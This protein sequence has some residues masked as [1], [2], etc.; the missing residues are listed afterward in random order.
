MII[1]DIHTALLPL[2]S[3]TPKGQVF[4]ITD[5]EVCA[6]CIQKSCHPSMVFMREFPTLILPSGEEHKSL[7]SIQKIWDFLLVHQATRQALII[8]LGGG[9]VTDMGG[10]AAATYM[11][12]VRFVNIPTTLLAM[13]DA[14]TGGKTGCNFNGIKN[15]I[16]TF[17]LPVSTLVFPPFL[18]SL[19]AQQWLSGYAEMLKHGLIADPKHWTDLLAWD[20]HTHDISALTP[21]IADSIAIKKHIVEAD[22]KEAGIRRAL[23]F[24]HTIGHAIEAT[25]IHQGLHPY[26]GYC[27]L[28]G[29]V[30]AL[31]LSVVHTACPRHLLTTLTQLMVE[32]YGKPQCNCH[33]QEQLIEWMLHD[34]KN[35]ASNNDQPHIN[36]TLLRDIG[37][38]LINQQLP[39]AAVNEALEYL[40]SI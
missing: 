36:F 18:A 23:N 5:E 31:Y 8:N 27:V 7:N 13:I 10:F 16:G 30:A 25:Y 32:H 14:S 28:W 29:M 26:H 34:K 24:G 21:L 3:D 22:P 6:S 37:Q 38:P 33:Q 17:T 35:I 39:I 11:R 19:P 20:I 9:V 40:F 2:I 4:V 15:T 1:S 12:G